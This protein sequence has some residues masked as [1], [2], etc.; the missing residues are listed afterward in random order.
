MFSDL[1]SLVVILAIALAVFAVARPVCERYIDAADFRRRRN[2]WLALTVLGFVTPSIWLY[3]A[4]AMPLMFFAAKRDPNPLALYT[5]LMF[6][7]P[8]YSVQIPS[9]GFNTLFALNHS[10]MMS[11]AILIPVV[12][13]RQAQQPGAARFTALDWILL[14]YCL[15]QLA[16]FTPY[17]PATNTLRRAVLALLDTYIVFYAFARLRPTHAALS[18]VAVM[19]CLVCGLLAPLAIFE[20]LRGWLLYETI[21]FHWNVGGSG[22]LMRGDALRAQ[23]STGHSLSLG[24][25]ISLGLGF[26]M[27]F[28]SQRARS[29][30]D[31]AITLVLC[32]GLIVSYSR[33]AW[34]TAMVLFIVYMAVRPGAAKVFVRVL[35]IVALLM[36]VAYLSPLKELVIDRLP[37]IGTSDQDTVDYR[38]RLAEVSWQLIKL[39]PWFGDP[40][41]TNSM[42]ELRQ[43]Q[44]IID[45]VNAYL[46][47]TLFYGFA[48]L[49]LF[50]SFLLLALWRCYR[51]LKSFGESDPGNA[52]LGSALV[53]CMVATLF[54]IGTAGV[55]SI[56]FLLAGLMASCAGMRSKVSTGSESR[57]SHLAARRAPS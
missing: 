25:I 33:G 36:I 26:W 42:E 9:I 40:L 31:T 53:A 57:F 16:L 39:H 44:G 3:A 13:R 12:W 56:Q 6:V 27:F 38:R 2:V 8:N 5:L 21:Q 1:K 17:D 32:G 37:I 10:R 11:L 7:I 45:I 35:P 19:F 43:G 28:I 51:A 24:Y 48:G 34:L 29:S 18:E 41:V 49:S 20:S 15:L 50:L 52:M 47:V 46:A 22:W 54:F 23:A 4:V 55:G 30:I 14:A